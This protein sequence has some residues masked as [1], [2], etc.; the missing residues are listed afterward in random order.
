MAEGTSTAGAREPWDDYGTQDSAE[1]QRR[2]ELKVDESKQ[3]GDRAYA[4][5]VTSAVANYE[6]AHELHPETEHDKDT[7]E[8]ANSL[9]ALVASWGAS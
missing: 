8:T 9:H 1:R 7:A 6:R 4:L 3:R 5:A 2:L